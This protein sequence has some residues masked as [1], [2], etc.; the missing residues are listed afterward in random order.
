[1]TFEIMITETL[2]SYVNLRCNKK[3]SNIPQVSRSLTVSV[4]R[5]HVKL[6]FVFSQ[7][8]PLR[9]LVFIFEILSQ[10]LAKRS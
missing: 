2:N 1:M 10:I 3:T 5:T 8:S 4:A 7:G 6:L 9:I